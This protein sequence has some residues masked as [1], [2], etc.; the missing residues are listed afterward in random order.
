MQFLLGVLAAVVAMLT[1][2]T[3]GRSFEVTCVGKFD[4][5]R[6][7]GLTD[8]FDEAAKASGAP[9]KVTINLVIV[10]GMGAAID[11]DYTPLTNDLAAYLDLYHAESIDSV[12]PDNPSGTAPARL[13]TRIYRSPDD[14]RELAVYE[15]H[16]WPLIQ[17]SKSRL[18]ADERYYPGKRARVN[19]RLK[20]SLVNERVTDPIIYLGPLG[21]PIRE[22]VKFTLCK[23]AGAT[24]LDK[25]CRGNG[26]PAPTVIV[27]ESLGSEIVYAALQEL[28]PGSESREVAA[29]TQSGVHVGQ[30]VAA[31]P[32]RE[33]TEFRTDVSHHIW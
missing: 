16:W 12:V 22:S 3:R 31:S 7:N 10:H 5:G 17:N 4:C 27:T 18:L 33:G 6:I 32:T 29:N 21:K 24:Y 25:Q 13:F 9:N 30:P 11:T 23:V 2:W 1:P 14:R 8:I 28:E 26:T 20:S 15:L 19:R